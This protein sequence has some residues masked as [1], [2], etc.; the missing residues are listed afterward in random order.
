MFAE[1]A[2]MLDAYSE[3][4]ILI[5]DRPCQSPFLK[6]KSFTLTAITTQKWQLPGIATRG[7]ELPIFAIL[8]VMLSKSDAPRRCVA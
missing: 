3:A 6:P 1:A 2:V 5:W 7:E 4:E 8:A